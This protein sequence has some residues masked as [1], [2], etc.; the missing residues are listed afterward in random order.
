VPGDA[1]KIAATPPRRK[2]GLYKIVYQE[3]DLVRPRAAGTAFSLEDYYR[4][5]KIKYTGAV[6]RELAHL[7]LLV[8][9]IYWDERY[10]RLLDKND[11]QALWEN[12]RRPRLRVVAD[13]SCDVGGALACTVASSYPDRPLYVFHPESGRITDGVHGHGPV[14]MAVEILPAEL[15]RE[16]SAYFS[17]RL[18]RYVPALAMINHQTDF[19]HL[20]LAL[21]LK[22]AVILWR[23]RLTPAYRYLADHL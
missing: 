8:N 10:P 6:S 19:K 14:V 5:G 18:K 3:K 1:A 15:P 9:C 16:A 23:G 17:R 12:D 4:H 22:R 21:E 2:D 20:D 11:F 7:T 13:I